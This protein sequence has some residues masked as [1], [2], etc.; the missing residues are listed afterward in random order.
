MIRWIVAANRYRHFTPESA[1][2]HIINCPVNT[3]QQTMPNWPW[4]EREQT[5]FKLVQYSILIE[6]DT[7]M[8]ES[9]HEPLR[10][11]SRGSPPSTSLDM[12]FPHCPAISTLARPSPTTN[13]PSH[14]HIYIDPHSSQIAALNQN[15]PSKSASQLVTKTTPKMPSS[16]YEV[17]KVEVKFLTKAPSQNQMLE[18]SLPVS[19][20]L[21]GLT[22]RGISLTVMHSCTDW[23]RLPKV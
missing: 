20:L 21:T 3:S 6:N 11:R 7:I 23:L 4:E 10:I 14:M 19:R 5:A 1:R 12:T 8:N 16:A 9:E 17:A 18:V 15:T 22:R 13:V 2:S